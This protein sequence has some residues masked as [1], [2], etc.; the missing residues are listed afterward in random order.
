[1]TGIRRVT[2]ATTPLA[3]G[4]WALGETRQIRG[5]NFDPYSFPRWCR[6]A[7]RGPPVLGNVG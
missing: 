3:R 6:F 1:M 5:A 2:L 7:V 4:V